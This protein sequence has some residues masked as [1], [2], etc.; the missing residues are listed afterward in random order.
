MSIT[1]TIPADLEPKLRR[2]ASE[3]GQRVEESS[4]VEG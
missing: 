1:I 3:N 4:G 2:R